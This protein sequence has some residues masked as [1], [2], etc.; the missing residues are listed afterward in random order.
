MNISTECLIFDR[1]TLKREPLNAKTQEISD[2][3]LVIR[4]HGSPLKLWSKVR[5]LIESM[6]VYMDGQVIWAKTSD[7]HSMV[8]LKFNMPL[9]FDMMA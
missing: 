3:G 6:D 1:D 5:I 9:K 8:G 4:Y 7:G 2:T